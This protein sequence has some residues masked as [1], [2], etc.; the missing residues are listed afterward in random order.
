MTSID[1]SN[2]TA[3]GPRS[4]EE[5]AV[6]GFGE[7]ARRDLSAA[8]RIWEPDAVDHFLAVGDAVGRDG[9][10][11]FFKE[12]F[13]AFPDFA[14]ETERILVADGTVVVQWHATATFT[15][16]PFQ[17]VRPTG[18]AIDFRG[19]DVVDMR[20]ERVRE[21]TIYWD[22]AGFARQIGMLPREGSAADRVMIAAFNAFTWARTLGGR[23]LRRA[24]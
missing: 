13:A 3:G 24:A 21:N 7:L 1:T 2:T 10:V 12:L 14:I 6:W 5:I 11:A 16:A 18:R 9:I 22:G 4:L 20:G 17:G 15:G 19:C 8:D 23:R